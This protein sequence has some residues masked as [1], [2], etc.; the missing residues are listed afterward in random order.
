MA[1]EL[2]N[3][4]FN[5]SVCVINSVRKLPNEKEYKVISYQLIKS[6]TSVG[7]NYQEAQGAVSQPDFTNKIGICLKE[8]RETN[9][10]IRII[11]AI[12]HSEKAD[13]E[14]LKQ[15]SNELRNILTSIYNKM[16][17]KK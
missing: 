3:R 8:I 15:E 6:A 16:K 17:L 4:L 1:N 7:A 12:C 11:I 10:W 14:A 5:F 9:Y 13:W 2:E